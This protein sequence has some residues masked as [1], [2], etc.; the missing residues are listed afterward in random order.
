M[1]KELAKLS[2]V[3]FEADMVAPADDEDPSRH[4]AVKILIDSSEPSAHRIARFHFGWEPVELDGNDA[5]AGIT[6]QALDESGRTVRLETDS[7]CTAIGF[8]ENESTPLVR[9]DHA[10]AEHVNLDRGILG[11]SLFCVGWLRRGP[12]GTIPENRADARM[13]ADT[14]IAD[15]NARS[16]AASKPGYSALDFAHHSATI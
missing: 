6:V 11:D 3:R 14:I 7:V 16:T 9:A 4:D 8:A 1:I 15:F 12:R 5:V 2:D 13:V 10:T